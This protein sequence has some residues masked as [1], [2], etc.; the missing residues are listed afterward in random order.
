MPTNRIQRY[1]P[2][3]TAPAATPSRPNPPTSIPAGFTVCPPQLASA[4]S[5]QQELYRQAYERARE[6]AQVPRHYRLLFS[7][8][9]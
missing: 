7:V 5:W 6:A 9:N 4:N 2:L 8:W 1:Q 3:A